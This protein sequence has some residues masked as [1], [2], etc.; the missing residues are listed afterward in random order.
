[1][2][3]RVC[4]YAALRSGSSEKSLV[5]ILGFLRDRVLYCYV[6]YLTLSHILMIHGDKVEYI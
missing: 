3:A 4:I 2:R 1:M 5:T 6:I